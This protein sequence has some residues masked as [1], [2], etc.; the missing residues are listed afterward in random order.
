MSSASCFPGVS[1]GF[2]YATP[3]RSSLKKDNHLGFPLNAT[4]EPT[5]RNSAIYFHP[6]AQFC[7]LIQRCLSLRVPFLDGLLNPYLEANAHQT[8]ST[9]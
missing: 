7:R 3:N 1:F 4:E 8:C 9:S 6:Y 5:W 2:P